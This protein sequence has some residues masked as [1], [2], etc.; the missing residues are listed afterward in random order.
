VLDQRAAV[1]RQELAGL[2]TG[3]AGY[4]ATLPRVTLIE[5]EYR[6]AMIRAELSWLAGVVDDLRTGALTWGEEIAEL[7]KASMSE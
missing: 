3:L 1:L 7:A 4:S 5:D 2:E 6:C